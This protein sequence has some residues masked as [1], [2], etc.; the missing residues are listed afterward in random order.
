MNI[1]RLI[2]L[3]NWKSAW[4]IFIV[5]LVGSVLGGLLMIFPT[6]IMLVTFLF[7]EVQMKQTANQYAFELTLPLTRNQYIRSKFLTTAWIA[8]ISLF[9]VVGTI[10]VIH[11]W[12]SAKMNPQDWTTVLFENDAL[13]Y[14]MQMFILFSASAL[15][16]LGVLQLLLFTLSF[17]K[18]ILVAVLLYIG[19][20]F[21]TFYGMQYIEKDMEVNPTPVEQLEEGDVIFSVTLEPFYLQVDLPNFVLF[22]LVVTSLI[23]YYVCYRLTLNR[24]Q[25]LRI[26]T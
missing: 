24:F 15:F 2:H 8:L 23:V 26:G 11:I 13:F 20:G 4:L 19:L 6:F 9:L 18:A 22:V 17:S 1:S 12:Q 16:I 5:I 7:F 21:I 25:K 10:A 14:L 3:S